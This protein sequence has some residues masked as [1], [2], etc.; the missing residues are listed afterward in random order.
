MIDG[1]AGS[2]AYRR[3]VHGTNLE[4]YLEE[5]ASRKSAPKAEIP[6]AYPRVQTTSSTR[7]EWVIAA[8]VEAKDVP[9]LARRTIVATPEMKTA[10]AVNVGKLKVNASEKEILA[11]G[12]L[13]PDGRIE[14]RVARGKPGDLTYRGRPSGPG[15]VLFGI[16][17]HPSDDGSDG[18]VDAPSKNHG[19]GDTDALFKSSIP[20]AT[21]YNGKIGWHEMVEGQ[22]IF[23]APRGIVSAQQRRSLQNNLDRSQQLFLTE[24]PPDGR[25]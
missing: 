10:A 14:V 21:V 7:D 22:L 9:R 13:M 16:H 15:K 5:Q 8:R 20:M 19:Y 25:K 2:D 6:R 24:T 11:F 1:A 3:V 4:H 23:T 12:Y 17:G 18:M